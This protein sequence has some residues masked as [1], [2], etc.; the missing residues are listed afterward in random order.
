MTDHQALKFLFDPHKSVSKPTA[1]MI[2]RWSLALAAYDYDIIHRPG[3]EIPQADFLSRYSCFS[4]AEAHCFASQAVP[5]S[6][7]DLVRETRRYYGSIL[8]A[9]RNG[10][11]PLLKKKY[12]MFFQIREELSVQPDGVLCRNDQLVIP[13]CLRKAVLEDV[14]RG[15]MGVEKMKS[16]ARPMCWWPEMDNDIKSTAA[17]CE[18]SHIKFL[19][20]RKIG[21]LDRRVTCHGN[22]CM[23]TSVDHFSGGIML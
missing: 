17:N 18:A 3:K 23:L 10:W 1:S 11:S 19:P 6:R 2:Q 22:G 21:S 12:P 8:S 14:H 4:P 9:L 16:L 20:D 7:S 15:H 13:P 5:I